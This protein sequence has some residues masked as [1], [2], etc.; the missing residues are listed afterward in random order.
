MIAAD[1]FL[2]AAQR[3]GFGFY[4]GVPCSFLTPLINRVISDS[5]TRYVGATSEGESV[6]IAAGAWL[7]GAGGVVMCQNSGLGNTINPLTSLNWPFRIP[8]LMIVTWRGQP[9]L[10]DEP[11]HEL[12]G[13]ATSSFL[14]DARVPHGPFPERVEDV[15]PALDLA[16]SQMDDLRLPYALIMAKGA[17]A[18]ETL[19]EAPR[20]PATAGDFVDLTVGGARPKRH[21]V[22]EHVLAGIPDAAPVI[23]TTGY[24][25][26]E[27]F[28]LAD[29]PQHLY[30]VGSM[31]GASAMALGVALN[32]DRPVVVLDGDGAALMKLGNMAT[33]GAQQPANLVHILLDNGMHESTG[34]QA[35]VSAGVD[36]ARI[37]LACGYRMAVR[38]DGIEGFE[39]GLGRCLAAT[40]P[41]LLH[42]RL[43]PG[44][45]PNL[46][47]PSVKP[48]EVAERFKAFVTSEEGARV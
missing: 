8:V 9:G 14:R 40:G 27:L 16:V 46:G 37:A 4:T 48:V 20:P 30:Q 19:D 25:G 26:R 35:T 11:Q 29:R 22:L 12:M 42:V 41:N 24:C 17:V 47:R 39:T 36:F 13:Q 15:E 7:A 18:D 23:A 31:G 21:E 28:T 38:A 43:A 5:G 10:K 44:A 45:M 2:D 33:I 32:T 34:G 6:A 1:D 3:R